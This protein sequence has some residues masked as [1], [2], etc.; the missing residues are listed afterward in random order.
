MRAVH[1]PSPSLRCLMT[2]MLQGRLAQILSMLWWV[3]TKLQQPPPQPLR[4]RQQ[5]RQNPPLPPQ[6]THLRPQM[7]QPLPQLPKVRAPRSACTGMPRS[8]IS[9]LTDMIRD[10]CSRLLLQSWLRLPGQGFFSREVC[11][12]LFHLNHFLW[13]SSYCNS[14]AGCGKCS[15]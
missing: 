2:G 12:L 6:S 3:T 15:R 5:P 1:P 14:A 7:L 13:P 9:L 8:A 4:R 10:G 11:A